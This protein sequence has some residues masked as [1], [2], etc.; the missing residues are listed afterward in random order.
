VYTS[1]KGTTNVCH[2]NERSIGLLFESLLC[3]TNLSSTMGGGGKDDDCNGNRD[4]ERDRVRNQAKNANSCENEEDDNRS[5]DDYIDLYAH[6]EQRTRRTSS[7]PRIISSAHAKS[8]NQIGKHNTV[9]T[10]ATATPT[11]TATSAPSKTITSTNKDNSNNT[12]NRKSVDDTAL[13]KS[14]NRVSPPNTTKPDRKSHKGILGSFLEHHQ[15]KQQPNRSGAR[16]SSRRTL[17]ESCTTLPSPSPSS[18]SVP[19][20]QNTSIN[21]RRNVSSRYALDSRKG[22]VASSYSSR[23]PAIRRQQSSNLNSSL[24]GEGLPNTSKTL[25]AR[26]SK[27]LTLPSTS[28]TSPYTSNPGRIMTETELQVKLM[29]IQGEQEE[30]HKKS[31]E[32]KRHMYHRQAY[33]RTPS[34]TTITMPNTVMQPVTLEKNAKG[35]PSS[36]RMSLASTINI[37]TTPVT[38]TT[39]T[40][41]GKQRRSHSHNELPSSTP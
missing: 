21:P 38:T 35:L 12:K 28:F 10:T 34:S 29:A 9:T 24:G 15:I 19:N 33:R 30:L 31:Q 6:V 3:N 40:T 17:Q 8:S 7:V 20:P 2:K 1:W 36:R 23:N 11:A 27:S 39:T 25:L 14:S 18:S 5:N 26:R 41:P 13:P 4:R 32:I 37:S 22:A 16:F